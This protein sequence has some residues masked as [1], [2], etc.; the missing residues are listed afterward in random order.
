MP[1]TATSSPSSR[2]ISR[3]ARAAGPSSTACARWRRA[4]GNSVEPLPEGL[5]SEIASRLPERQRGRGAAADAAA[6]PP[7]A[8][9]PFRAPSDGRAAPPAHRGHH[10]RRPRRGRRR[11]GR[12][13][14]HRA[15]AGRQQGLGPAGRR[16][17]ARH[18][19]VAA[20]LRTPGHRLVDARLALARASW[21]SSWWCPPGR[22]IWSRRSCRRCGGDRTYQLWAIEG[23]A[24]RS[25]SACSAARPA[26]PPSPWP[27]RH[28]PSH[29][30][31]TA[32][33]AG[34][35]GDSPPAPI[36]ATGT[37]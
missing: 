1:S 26:R 20:A 19:P 33:P 9:S 30:S 37:V 23:T 28:R 12:R 18:G 14:R 24:G 8:G 16:G 17:R 27:A 3:P 29:L 35:F 32:E 31:I 4:M 5:W 6:R 36:V 34:R 21:R 7:R 2:S 15:G 22:A 25:P 10:R 11:R 13:A